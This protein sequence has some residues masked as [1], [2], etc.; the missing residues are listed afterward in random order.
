MYVYDTAR[1]PSN[2]QARHLKTPEPERLPEQWLMTLRA[3]C[4]Q[5][6]IENRAK[7]SSLTPTCQALP[8]QGVKTNIK[9]TLKKRLRQVRT[10]PVMDAPL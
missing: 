7:A 5:E 1:V 2:E 8:A 10:T 4:T 6:N 3:W 9:N